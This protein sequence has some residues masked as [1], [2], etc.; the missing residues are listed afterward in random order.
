V[1]M[2]DISARK[3]T[4][5]ALGE[6]VM[7]MTIPWTKFVEMERHVDKSFFQRETWRALQKN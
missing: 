6:H 4:R 5:A 2:T 1:G 3:N 7:S